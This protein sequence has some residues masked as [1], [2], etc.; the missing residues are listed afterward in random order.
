[1]LASDSATSRSASASAA[2]ARPVPK[3]TRAAPA[4][5]YGA[6]LS[7]AREHVDRAVDPRDERPDE[8]ARRRDRIDAVD[9]GFEVGGS[10]LD[11][12][13]EVAAPLQEDVDA[14]IEDERGRGGAHRPQQ[15]GLLVESEE[16]P[17]ARVLEVDPGR[18]RGERAGRRTRRIAVARLEVRRQGHVDRSRDPSDGLQHH[19]DRRPLAVL[20]P[21][22]A[23]DA[24][25]RRRER[26]AAGHLREGAG[27]RDVPR[28]RQHEH[29]R[30]PVER[31]QRV[32]GVH[33]A[34]IL[35][36][37]PALPLEGRR[38]GVSPS[39]TAGRAPPRASRGAPA[40]SLALTPSAARADRSRRP[41]PPAGAARARAY[42]PRSA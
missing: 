9:A 7:R 6:R 2:R 19:V 20:P 33:A 34:T 39:R 38:A 5:A 15:L 27:A 25:A 8:L 12:L 28:I 32:G 11:R 18:P 3:V 1:M 37:N 35:R 22:G 14:R 29:R 42:L 4:A 41:S 21:E 36:G 26:A 16:R 31:A 30:R 24:A 40:A 17:A 23:R 13:V 10:A